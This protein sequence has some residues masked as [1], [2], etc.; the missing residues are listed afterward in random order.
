[1]SLFSGLWALGSF[2]V[3]LFIAAALVPEDRELDPDE[4]SWG[5][6]YFHAFVGILIGGLLTAL[7]AWIFW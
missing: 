1:M 7:G 4:V 5:I 3:G 2:I 6:I